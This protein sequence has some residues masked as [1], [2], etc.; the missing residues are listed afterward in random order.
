[1]VPLYLSF[2]PVNIY[3]AWL[4]SGNI[5]AWISAIDPGLTIVLQQQT[6]KFYG[7]G[8]LK[9]VGELICSGLILSCLILIIALSLGL[10]S[11]YFIINLLNLSLDVDNLLILKAFKFAFLEPFNA[12]FFIHFKPLIMDCKQAFPQDY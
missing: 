7:A 11:S 4:A 3:G 6:S 5:L 1:M 10:I 8:K 12:F 2:I 9:K